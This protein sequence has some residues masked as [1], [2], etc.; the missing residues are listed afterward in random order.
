MWRAR[1]SLVP[2]SAALEW[3]S[4]ALLLVLF[5]VVI[6]ARESLAQFHW[7]ALPAV[8]LPFVIVALAGYWL[9]RMNVHITFAHVPRVA[10]PF[11][12]APLLQRVPLDVTAWLVRAQALLL[13][14]PLVPIHLV[15]HR[16]AQTITL[17]AQRISRNWLELRIL[18]EA[19]IECA[20]TF[21]S[22]G[23]DWI[24]SPF[25]TL[26]RIAAGMTRPPQVIVLRC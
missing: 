7:R 24:T 11:E 13:S 16:A 25:H 17:F 21:T 5:A 2:R 3:L 10:L 9:R 19:V 22:A 23:L 20:F 4:R 18:L 8:L 26:L 1:A 15:E 14:M 12:A 6:M